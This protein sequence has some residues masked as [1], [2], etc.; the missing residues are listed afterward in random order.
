MTTD[1][2]PLDQEH[3]DQLLNTTAKLLQRTKEGK[4]AQIVAHAKP[5][6]SE[7]IEEWGVEP[8]SLLELAIPVKAYPFTSAEISIL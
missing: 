6:L 2:G 8:Y 5:E 3:L 4:A 7:K 1:N